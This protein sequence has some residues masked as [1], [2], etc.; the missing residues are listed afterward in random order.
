MSDPQMQRLMAHAHDLLERGQIDRAIDC[1]TNLLGEHP[2]E[3]DAHALLAIALIRRKRL[4]AARLEADTAARLDPD[5][6]HAH[7]ALAAVLE[8]QRK[9][10]EA[11]RELSLAEQ[12]APESA[13]VQAQ[14]ASLYRAWGRKRDAMDRAV[15]ACELDPEDHEHQAL[16]AWLEYEAGNR[17]AARAYAVS[18]LEA[19]PAL[20]DALVVLGH[21]DLA[22]G[23]VE[24]AHEHAVWALQNDPTDER[25]LTL[26]CAI[27][28]R[29]SPLLGLWWRFQNYLSAGSQR[30]TILLLVGA[31]LV[32]RVLG[33][34]LNDNGYDT[35][36][37]W[38]TSA[39]FGFCAYTWIAP[40]L[41]WKSV[42]HELESVSL[43]RN[44]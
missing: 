28:A 34:A 12:M 15:R 2:D 25:A 7:I 20:I 38:L 32:Y 24:R 10:V 39:W 40:S 11:E 23:R 14:L 18:A 8:A 33:I 31:Y 19:D 17:A 27:K 35:W 22:D 26:L 42:K 36:L 16:R 5:S 30:R 21:C 9:F 3:S 13:T 29:R 43:P 44:Y 41:F 37:P 1:L 4:Y 6:L